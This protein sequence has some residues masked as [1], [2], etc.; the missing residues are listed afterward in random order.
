MT[1]AIQFDGADFFLTVTGDDNAP[2]LRRLHGVRDK[3]ECVE[4]TN[5]LFQIK[6][7]EILHDIK[8]KQI[9]GRVVGSVWTIEYQKR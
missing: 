1:N 7:K 4:L 9:F 3:K 6:L 5:R 2:E 8:V